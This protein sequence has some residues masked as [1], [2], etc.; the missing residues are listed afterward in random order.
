MSCKR[1]RQV[2]RRASWLRIDI[3]SRAWAP[4]LSV[5]ICAISGSDVVCSA[6]RS[7]RLRPRCCQ[8]RPSRPNGTD[9]AAAKAKPHWEVRVA[10]IMKLNWLIRINGSQSCNTGSHLSR[11][12]TADLPWLMR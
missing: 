10:P 11:W 9:N 7:K 2:F 4:R 5:Y 6:R 3:S 1:V 12:G 8:L